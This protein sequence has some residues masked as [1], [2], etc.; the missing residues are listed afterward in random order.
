MIAIVDLKPNKDLERKVKA[1]KR[2][3]A[4]RKEKDSDAEEIVSE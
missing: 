2:R 4:Q 1:F 3:E